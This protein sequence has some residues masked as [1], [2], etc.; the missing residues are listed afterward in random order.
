[1]IIALEY[2]PVPGLAISILIFAMQW[3]FND[4][5]HTVR[6]LKQAYGRWVVTIGSG[7]TI[8]CLVL[9]LAK[10]FGGRDPELIPERVKVILIQMPMIIG[11]IA[12]GLVLITL[13]IR[14]KERIFITLSRINLG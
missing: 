4:E 5:S 12:L 1:M 3:K 10:L 7:I 2:W 9:M 8:F 14:H 11:P 13:A 6:S